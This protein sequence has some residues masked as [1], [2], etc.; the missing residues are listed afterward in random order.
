MIT[1]SCCFPYTASQLL[2]E[3]TPAPL[4]Q[5]S[6]EFQ[7]VLYGVGSLVRKYDICRE[8]V[9]QVPVLGGQPKIVCPV[10][11]VCQ[12]RI[13]ECPTGASTMWLICKCP[14]CY[15]DPFII[16]T[17]TTSPTY[18]YQYHP[19]A[20][21]TN[22]IVVH[23]EATNDAYLA[24][25]A[26]PRDLPKMYEIVLGGWQNK[27]SVL[28]RCKQCRVLAW[29]PTNGILPN[30]V[31]QSF[32]IRF[33]D[34]VVAIGLTGFPSLFQYHDPD[35]LPVRYVGFATRLG[36]AGTFRFIDMDAI[37]HITVNFEPSGD[38]TGCSPVVTVDEKSSPTVMPG[39]VPS[40]FV[41]LYISSNTDVIVS[42][43]NDKDPSGSETYRILIGHGTGVRSSIVY[44]S[45]EDQRCAEVFSAETF[46]LLGQ[47]RMYGFWLDAGQTAE[48][49]ITFG[50]EGHPA[51]LSFRPE[52]NLLREGFHVSISVHHTGLAN[53]IIC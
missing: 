5:P 46:N 28:R 20:L 38:F 47:D 6:C 36:S 48:G 49:A 16:H 7:D 32:W 10:A 2:D 12:N 35:P 25:S 37:E 50:R 11:K 26:E 51:F 45:E 14:Y 43:S 23:I 15:K 42:L 52:I 22:R 8:C 39:P 34:G 3:T 9:C 13:D 1:I 44:C 30:K 19:V 29:A 4:S 24:F 41:F 31:D 27:Y 53:V 18:Y 33:D 17:Y 21:A 40:N